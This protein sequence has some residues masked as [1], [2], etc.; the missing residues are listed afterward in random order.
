MKLL[1]LLIVLGFMRAGMSCQW[2]R[3]DDW[4]NV[5]Q[6]WAD[7][8][9]VDPA[10]RYICAVVLTSV[11]LA[12]ITHLLKNQLWGIVGLL[13]NVAILFYVIGRSQLAQALHHYLSD[14]RTGD[15]EGAA[16]HAQQH[17]GIDMQQINSGVDLH[18]Q[19]RSRVLYVGLL[20]F[21]AAVF[22]Y[23]IFGVMGALIPL[24]TRIYV[25]Q[26]SGEAK[27]WA[28]QA[29]EVVEWLPARLL[30]LTFAVAGNFGACFG[31]WS[32][33][34]F[35][36]HLSNMDFLAI[37]GM[38]AIGLTDIV[39]EDQHQDGEL[40]REYLYKTEQE[41]R[42][43]SALVDRSRYVWFAIVSVAVVLGWL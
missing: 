6:H 13:I 3:R 27:L 36:F 24:L 41:I 7:H 10:T 21:F 33:Y 43:L 37:C 11:A 38:S 4:F 16:L 5:I 2:F 20:D 1:A 19:M 31:E 22:W 28:L 18:Y 25:Q 40:S 34:A 8:N 32:E 15:L 35:K 26:S 29:Q 23:L 17:F 9:I 12:L 14:W 39:E 42:A 30:G